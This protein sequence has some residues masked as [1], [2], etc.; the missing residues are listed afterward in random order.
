[1]GEAPSLS[2]SPLPVG[3]F[4]IEFPKEP[5][6][7]EAHPC[8]GHA[9]TAT[10]AVARSLAVGGG[11]PAAMWTH[12]KEPLR[13]CVLTVMLLIQHVPAMLHGKDLA[14]L[15]AMILGLPEQYSP[16]GLWPGRWMHCLVSSSWLMVRWLEWPFKGCL[17]GCCRDGR[18]RH[19]P[20]P[21]LRCDSRRGSRQAPSYKTPEGS[22]L[23]GGLD[24]Q[25]WSAFI[26]ALE[27]GVHASL[28]QGRWKQ[29]AAAA[30][31]PAPLGVS[32]P[33]LR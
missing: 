7:G 8:L 27:E 30:G 23:F 21:A 10:P 15:P 1:M 25:Q 29:A 2:F 16:P 12:A 20:T 4:A 31:K 24:A 22:S 26:A 19:G 17:R 6:S 14:G 18:E 9:V 32:C 5:A 11:G 13:R 3:T 28:A 33:H